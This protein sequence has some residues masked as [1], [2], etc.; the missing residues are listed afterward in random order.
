MPLPATIHALSEFVDQ[1]IVIDPSVTYWYEGRCPQ[2]NQ[3]LRLPRTSLAESIADGLMQHLATRACF[4]REGKMYGVLLVETAAGEQQ[5]LQAFSGLLQGESLVEGW[6]PPIS[7]QERIRLVEA[8]TLEKLNAIK[9]ELLMLE[10]ISERQKYEALA[11]EFETKLFDLKTD[12]QICKQER[13]HQRQQLLEILTGDLLE[14][15]L[16]QLNEQSRQAGMVRRRLKQERDAALHPLK[17]AIEQADARIRQL[18]LRRKVLSRHLQ[19]QMHYAFCLTNFA[20]KTASLQHLISG[21]GLPTGTGD[22]C[23]PKLLHYAATHALK[24]LAMAEFWWG[25]NTEDKVVGEFYG[26]CIERCQPILGFLLSGLPQEPQ[27]EPQ[28]EKMTDRS[29]AV[30]Y[31]DDWLIAID[32]PAGLLSVPG[33]YLDRQDSVLSRLRERYPNLMTTHRLDQDTSGILLLAKDHATHRALSQQFQQ[34]QTHKVYE[35]ILVGSVTPAQGTIDLP[36]RSDFAHRPRQRVDLLH[37]K[38]SLS[39][40]RV[41]AAGELTRMEWIPITGRTHQLRV[42]AAV[43][44]GAPILGDRLYGWGTNAERLYL[45]ARELQFLHLQSSQP[46]QLQSKTPF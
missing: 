38:P 7:G 3:L 45:H 37:G 35:A 46:I 1:T 2:S 25:S 5:V 18:K 20:G 42:H 19:T 40:F 10:Q 30:L 6:V 22:C 29:L 11:Q 36:L 39:H 8:E 23:A 9:Q 34:R 14:T 16:E 24:P 28:I 43:G 31:E 32:K 15:A 41:L 17:Q 33:R 4:S 21:G 27:P 44:L 12:Q 26:A 13:L